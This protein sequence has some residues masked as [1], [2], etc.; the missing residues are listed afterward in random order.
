MLHAG[1]NENH[2]DY[3][4]SLHHGGR[5]YNEHVNVSFQ[6]CDSCAEGGGIDAVSKQD[7]LLVTSKNRIKNTIVYHDRLRTDISRCNKNETGGRFV[8]QA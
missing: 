3:H 5:T 7:P 1:L 4:Y 8:A 6:L 2:K